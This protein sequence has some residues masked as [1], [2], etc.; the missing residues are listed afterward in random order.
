MKKRNS[1]II[2]CLSSIVLFSFQ[3]ITEVKAVS[4]VH[5]FKKTPVVSRS[6]QNDDFTYNFNRINRR[7][8]KAKTDWFTDKIGKNSG[9][10]HYYRVATNE[11]VS[12]DDVALVNRNV[13]RPIT[14][15]TGHNI[16]KLNYKTY[17]FS[18]TGRRLSAGTWASNERVQLPRGIS[19][20]KVGPNEWVQN[21]HY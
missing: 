3:N 19:Y 16:W 10:D 6:E 12:T 11:W 2:F 20:C 1:M 9:N 17:E 15:S 14:I 5:T 4:F 18:Y 21:I 13:D 7:N 8:L